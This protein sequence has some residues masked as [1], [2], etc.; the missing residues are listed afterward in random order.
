MKYGVTTYL[1]SADFTP[2]HFSILPSIKAAGFDGVEIPVFRPSQF[3]AREIRRGLDAAGLEC[4]VACALV[5][6]LSLASD[7][8]DLRR[9]SI[10][11]VGDV[12]KAAAEVGARIVAGPLYTPVG[13]RPGRRSADEWSRV[14]E[15]YQE[16][17][18][19][20]A[21]SGVSV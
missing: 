1:W 21:S 15:A 7:D 4:A 20:L 14:V 3:A 6:G 16:L 12:A 2:Q 11:H 17:G 13:Y 18:P 5:D 9:K 10:A 19:T 8:A